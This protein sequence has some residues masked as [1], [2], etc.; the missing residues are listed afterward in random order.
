M[1]TIQDL[2]KVPH[3]KQTSRERLKLDL[4][5]FKNE[6]RNKLLKLQLEASSSPDWLFKER[7]KSALDNVYILIGFRRAAMSAI[8]IVSF[9][10]DPTLENYFYF[11]NEFDTLA[12]EINFMLK[13]ATARHY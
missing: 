8:S 13:R 9:D 2:K 1:R 11:C 10:E 12:N 7:Y 4:Y 5:N 3:Y 6:F